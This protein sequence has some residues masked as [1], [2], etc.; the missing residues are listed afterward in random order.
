MLEAPAFGTRLPVRIYTTVDGLGRDAVTC[1]VPDSCLCAIRKAVQTLDA[2]AVARS[3]SDEQTAQLRRSAAA[4]KS[5][6]DQAREG[7]ART[8]GHIENLECQIRETVSGFG[9]Q[10]EVLERLAEAVKLLQDLARRGQQP[11]AAGA[12][13]MA[14]IYT[15]Q[16]ERAVH[17]EIFDSTPHDLGE[18]GE[19]PQGATPDDNVEF[20]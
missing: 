8:M 9:S 20:F 3:D 5:I 15:M 18:K 1:I 4:S 11:D 16:S 12:A 2:V 19:A 7:Y 14:A 13:Q 17:R 10:G 6:Q